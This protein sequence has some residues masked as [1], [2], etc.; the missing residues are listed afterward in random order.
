VPV[1]RAGPFYGHEFDHGSQSI[2]LPSCS[3]VLGGFIRRSV[4]DLTD[5]PLSV[6]LLD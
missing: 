4:K 1:A 3:M 2:S 5:R 6:L